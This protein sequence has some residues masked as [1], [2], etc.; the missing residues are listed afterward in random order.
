M[1]EKIW[2]LYCNSQ[3]QSWKSLIAQASLEQHSRFLTP[4]S[5]PLQKTKELTS[6]TSRRQIPGQRN[7]QLYRIL[8]PVN[9]W[10]VR[11]GLAI[12]T[13]SSRSSCVCLASVGSVEIV[14]GCRDQC[15]VSNSEFSSTERARQARRE[16][17]REAERK[18]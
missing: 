16:H 10:R 5:I 18:R 3:L 2:H 1:F 12:R 13:R 15:R 17:Q 7:W 8:L 4:K 6:K 9:R 11:G 14:T